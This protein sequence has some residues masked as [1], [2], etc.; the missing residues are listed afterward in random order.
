MHNTAESLL[1]NFEETANISV[2]QVY[3]EFLISI[4]HIDRLKNENTVQLWI[5]R[6]MDRLKQKLD[7]KALE[8]IS[9]NRDIPTIDW[10]QKKLMYIIRF[11][12]QEFSQMAR[13]V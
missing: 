1:N 13:Y 11:H 4:K 3:A 9:G 12:L 5:R 2:N 8:Y 10:F 7:G 6:H